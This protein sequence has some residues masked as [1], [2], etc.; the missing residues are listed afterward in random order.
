MP[1]TFFITTPIYYVNDKPHIG[2]ALTTTV[3]DCLARFNRL[4]GKKT[5]FSVGTDEHGAKIAQAAAASGQTPEEFVKVLSLN[6]KQNWRNLNISFDDF[7]RTEDERH[8]KAVAIFLNKLK[9]SGY[10]YKGKYE[11][12]YCDG[13]EA[14]YEQSELNNGSCF[15]HNRPARLIKEEN[16]FFK[17]SSFADILKEKI[18]SDEIKILPLNR[19]NEVL[20]FID[21]GLKDISISRQSVAWGIPLPFDEAQV[22]YVWVDALINYISVIGFGY[23]QEK[24][25]EFW[26]ADLHLLGKDISRFH[27]IIWPALLIANGLKPP[28]SLFV[29]SFF[30]LEGKKISKSLGN[31]ISPDDLIGKFGVDGSRYLLL[32]FF[33]KEN[34]IDIQIK[35]LEDTYNADL[36]FGLGNLFSRVLTVALTKNINEITFIPGSLDKE[37]EAKLSDNIANY[38]NAFQE[39]DFARAIGAILQ[40][41]SLGDVLFD[42]QKPWSL[43]P[44]DPKLKNIINF[45]VENLRILSILIFPFMP[46]TSFKI[47][48][49]LGLDTFE[50]LPKNILEKRLSLGYESMVIKENPPHLFT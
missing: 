19:K 21:Q 20:S 42:K 48:K 47:R 43:S 16:W 29:H 25:N 45:A 39:I 27:C 35:K 6:F 1:D 9:D 50:K 8:K 12:F 44:E 18:T 17:L 30:T 37:L 22:T 26:P 5:F 10:I 31:V 4:R 41:I 32:K 3:A 40:N 2:S 7:I 23:D 49:A 13:C 33:P 24:F 38:L 11:G 14:F 28:K 34:D 15:I 46:E 36:K